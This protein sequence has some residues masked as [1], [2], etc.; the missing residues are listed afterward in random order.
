MT[1]RAED[2]DAQAVIRWL[3]S[4]DQSDPAEWLASVLRRPEWHS[5]AAC[6]GM[7]TEVFFPTR[8]ANLDAARAICATCP[9]TRECLTAALESDTVGVWAG[10]S[11]RGRRP[12]RRDAG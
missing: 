6:R 7:G 9:V 12:M 1:D 10:T 2:T 3:M 11:E 5:R 4:T 8:G